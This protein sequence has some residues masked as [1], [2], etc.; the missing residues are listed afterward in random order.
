MKIKGFWKGYVDLCKASLEWLKD[1][2]LLYI[3]I[4]IVFAVIY[5]G[6]SVIAD[7]KFWKTTDKISDDEDID[8][9]DN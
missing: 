7:L 8:F 4:C 9:L 3:L 5:V 2:W 1:Y 6:P